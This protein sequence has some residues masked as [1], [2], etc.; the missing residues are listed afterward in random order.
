MQ[1]SLVAAALVICCARSVV[2]CSPVAIITATGSA[3]LG[4]VAVA[5]A[6]ERGH[7]HAAKKVSFCN[8]AVHTCTAS[9]VYSF[10]V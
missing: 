2:N 4:G 10:R 1:V 5:L 8:C 7:V 9:V 6:T 3:M